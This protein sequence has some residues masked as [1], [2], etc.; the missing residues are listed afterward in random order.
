VDS[1]FDR[2]CEFVVKTLEGHVSDDP[3]DS[4]GFTVWGLS[5]RYNPEVT[6]DMTYEQAKKIYRAKY[7]RLDCSR[8]D[9]PL[10]LCFFDGFVNPQD[11]PSV[12]GVG[13]DEIVKYLGPWESREPYRYAY[14]FLILRADRYARRSA[15]R[16][17]R[18]HIRRIGNLLRFIENSKP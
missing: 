5:S 2:A 15:D 10:D 3:N 12:P 9:W 1:N 11:D 18:G 14:A 7:W 16:Y 6:R 8:A 13:N 4:G 17:V